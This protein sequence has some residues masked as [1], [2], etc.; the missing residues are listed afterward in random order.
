LEQPI[1]L[2]KLNIFVFYYCDKIN[3]MKQKVKNQK[4][5]KKRK[6]LKKLLPDDVTLTVFKF[7]SNTFHNLTV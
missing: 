6:T 2:A 5:K 4:S 7:F 1:V 3:K